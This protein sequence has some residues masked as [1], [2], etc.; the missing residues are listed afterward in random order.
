MVGLL[1]V[2]APGFDSG[3]DALAA[4]GRDSFNLE[5]N[6]SAARFANTKSFT[7][8]PLNGPYR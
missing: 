6:Q 3:L 1:G 8:S 4:G 7:F 2:P 5:D